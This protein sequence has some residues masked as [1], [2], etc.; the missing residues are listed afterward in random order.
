[1]TVDAKLIDAA[2]RRGWRLDPAIADGR[3]QPRIAVLGAGHSGPVIARAAVE[4]GYEVAIAGSADPQRIAL[5]SQ[6]LVPGARPLWAPDAV[7]DADVVV[8]AIPIHRFPVLDPALLPD[9]LVVDV[10]N[11]WPPVDGIQAMF[12]DRSQGT[13]EIVQARLAE[14]TVVKTLNHLGYHE[15]DED[16]RPAGTPGRRAVGVAADDPA[17]LDL[18]SQIVE[19]LG[20]DAVRLDSLRAGRIFEAGGPVFGASLSRDDF[21]RAAQ[22]EAA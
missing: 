12:E 5:I 10:M 8:L 9:K 19:R 4:A 17:A 18:V 3:R 20:F 22:A 11:Y 21:R 1:M 2:Q 6:V 15:L 13:S 7:A 14:S 16:R